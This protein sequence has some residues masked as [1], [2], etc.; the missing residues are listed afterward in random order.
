MEIFGNIW[1]LQDALWKLRNCSNFFFCIEFFFLCLLHMKYKDV[2]AYHQCWKENLYR[3]YYI[4]YAI[5]V[6]KTAIFII[7]LFYFV[8]IFLFYFMYPY[9]FEY[10][11]YFLS[12]KLRLWQLHWD[13]FQSYVI[14]IW[15]LFWLKYFCRT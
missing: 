12:V 4:L 1:R 9:S 13:L 2:F 14:V 10:T 7:A 11:Y 6:V 15:L 8:K 5:C 3:W